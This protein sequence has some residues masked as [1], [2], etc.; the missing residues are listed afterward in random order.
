MTIEEYQHTLAAATGHGWGFLAAYG[1]TWLVCSW[2]WRRWGARVG[3]Y[4]TLFQG[5]V[6]LPL[7][8]WLTAL[9]PGPARPE[10]DGMQGLSVLLSMGQLLGLPI[11]IYLVARGQYSRAPL[12]MVIL[13]AVHFA[14][15]SWLYATPL[16]LVMGGAISVGAAFA[17]A[18]ARR[19]HAVADPDVLGSARVCLST[20]VVMLFSAGVA[21]VL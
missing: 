9:T 19:G 17:D 8:L 21:W 3:A 20:G 6:A 18:S 1:L 10:M 7:A 5:M 4:C 2:C 14:P 15:Y 16:Y 11:V 12:A 13:L